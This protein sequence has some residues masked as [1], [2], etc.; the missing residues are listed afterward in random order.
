MKAKVEFGAAFAGKMECDRGTFNV[1]DG[2]L[3]PYDM[4]LGALASCIHSTF[5]SI[6]AKKRINI[7][8]CTYDIT[9][10]KRDEIPTHLKTVHLDVTVKNP[11]KREGVEDAFELA[12]RYCSVY[13]TFSQVAQMSHTFVIEG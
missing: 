11:S 8:N 10:E 6:L 2:G 9:G 13:F 7:E 4:M 1:G 5:M 3:Y 12:L